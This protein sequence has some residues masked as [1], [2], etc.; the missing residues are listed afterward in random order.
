MLHICFLLTAKAYNI[1]MG[2]FHPQSHTI[3]Q[4]RIPNGINQKQRNDNG[5]IRKV[6]VAERVKDEFI[7]HSNKEVYA[8]F[9]SSDDMQHI[10]EEDF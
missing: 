8:I 2:L 9:Y 7:K 5:T 4:S 6:M 3:E 1:F 10:D